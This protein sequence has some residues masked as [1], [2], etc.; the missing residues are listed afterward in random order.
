MN[1]RIIQKRKMFY[2]ILQILIQFHHV[3]HGTDPLFFTPGLFC[4]SFGDCIQ[5]CNSDNVDIIHQ[6]TPKGK[7]FLHLPRKSKKRRPQ[8]E[9]P[10]C[11]FRAFIVLRP[12][13]SRS[14]LPV[15]IPPL[16]VS[17]IHSLN[18][19]L[20]RCDVRGERNAVLVAERNHV[21]ELHVVA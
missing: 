11:R 15:Q 12:P 10:Y 8:H 5:L 9:L 18:Q 21:I 2:Y 3:G 14:A 6:K 7:H 19:H 20:R 1:I 17:V 16:E 13:V 4:G